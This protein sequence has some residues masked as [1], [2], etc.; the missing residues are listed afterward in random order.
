[1]KGQE[2]PTPSLRNSMLTAMDRLVGR[3]LKAIKVQ[4]K[5]YNIEFK[6]KIV[7]TSLAEMLHVFAAPVPG[8]EKFCSAPAP[9]LRTP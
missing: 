9:T 4:Y 5:K 7:L 6:F 3:V 2:R 1:V 8:G